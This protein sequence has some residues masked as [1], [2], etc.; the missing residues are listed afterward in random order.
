MPPYAD[1]AEE[2]AVDF[3][4]NPV[5]Y[6]AEADLQA[7]LFG[8]ARDRVNPTKATVQQPTL[9]GT[10]E[11]SFKRDYWKT[12]QEDLADAGEIHRVHTEVSVRKGERLDIAVFEPILSESIQ[13]VSGGSKRFAESDLEAALE[14]KFVKNKMSFP[15]RPG[16]TVSDLADEMP[17]VD[18][19]LGRGTNEEPILD[20][21]ENKLRSDIEELNELTAVDH[22]YLVIVSNNNY[23]YHAPTAAETSE[24]RYGELY[25]RMGEAAR[26]WLADNASDD[27]D[28]LYA[29]P[30]GSVWLTR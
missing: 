22:R 5:D 12:A 16:Y 25:Q 30:R 15:R 13:W 10:A 3:E 20:L 1:L 23:L 18:R 19:L 17:S 6:V 9:E 7:T 28:V 2:L 21:S 11:D 8:L 4:S 26:V 24:Y 27:V 29:H 14:L